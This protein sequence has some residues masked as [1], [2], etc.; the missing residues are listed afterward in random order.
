MSTPIQAS[1]PSSAPAAALTPQQLD[2]RKKLAAKGIHENMYLLH[3]CKMTQDPGV[4]DLLLRAVNPKDLQGYVGERLLLEAED[5]KTIEKIISAGASYPKGEA[6]F[7]FLYEAAEDG[8]DA[9]V[10]ELILRESI[11]ST[12]LGKA[13][14]YPF[15]SMVCAENPDPASIK[16]LLEAG[17]SPDEPN[18]YGSAPLGILTHRSYT[19]GSGWNRGI[20]LVDDIVEMLLKAGANPNAPFRDYF[21]EARGVGL[22]EPSPNPLF[23]LMIR[24]KDHQEMPP[25]YKERVYRAMQLLIDAGADVRARDGQG[26]TVLDLARAAGDPKAVEI[27]EK[28]VSRAEKA[29]RKGK[30]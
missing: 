25:Q 14:G 29:R 13:K 23:G 7:P 16:L 4:F 10:I 17:A 30:K 9:K 18:L 26:Q 28:A 24:H 6:G 11:G 21:T 15:I 2:A 20:M 22:W 27:L 1:A 5:S 12:S 3:L 8:K 19:T